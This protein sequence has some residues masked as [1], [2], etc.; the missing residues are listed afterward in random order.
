MRQGKRSGKLNEMNE[1]VTFQKAKK[2]RPFKRKSKR[3]GAIETNNFSGT[4]K[5]GLHRIMLLQRR[6]V[7]R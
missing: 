1:W 7:C 3:Q 5:Q 4:E 6:L 2:Q